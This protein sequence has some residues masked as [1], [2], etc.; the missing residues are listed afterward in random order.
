MHNGS[1]LKFSAHVC[2]IAVHAFHTANLILKCLYSKDPGV[3]WHAFE[4]YFC[5]V[6][7]YVQCVWSPHSIE[8]I[9]LIESVQ[10]RLIKRLI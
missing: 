9:K 3:V 1:E 6:F 10:Q 7:E 2:I 8:D 5:L 4:V